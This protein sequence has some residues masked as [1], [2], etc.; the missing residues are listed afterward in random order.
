MNAPLNAE[1][2][3]QKYLGG[4][5]VA[6]ILGISPWKTPLDVYL[7]KIQPRVEVTDP[8]KLKLFRRGHRM[9]PYV[10]DLLAEEENLTIVARGNRYIDKQH[11]FIAAEIDAEAEGNLNIEIKTVSPFKAKEWGEQQTDEIPVHYTA[12]VMHGLM[13]TDRET[14]ILGVLIGGDDFRVYRVLR[15][16]EIISAIRESE[17]AFWDRIQNRLPPEPS[18]VGDIARLYGATD[19]GGSIEATDAIAATVRDMQIAVAEMKSLA[20]QVEGHKERIQ[21]FMGSTAVLTQGSEVLAT[22]KSQNASRFDQGAFKAAHPDL[23][24]QFKKS[25]ET[26]VFRLK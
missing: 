4:S 2:N 6:A 1:L 8:A 12:Q 16:E 24:E 3:R 5:D 10:I 22:W 25:S 7:D 17:I 23:Y 19:S 13:V 18:T 11:G 21:L 26:R 14:C 20:E 15:D 9:E